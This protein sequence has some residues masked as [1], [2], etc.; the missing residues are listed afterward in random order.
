MIESKVNK[1]LEKKIDL[2]V[3]GILTTEEIDELWIELIQDGYYLD[4][5]KSV[6][7]LKAVIDQKEESQEKS[8][9]FTFQKVARY[10]AAAAVFVIVSIAGIL[11]YSSS[12]NEMVSP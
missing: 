3:N 2:Y 4:Y 11:N 9:I 1:E 5:M 10:A 7:N 8:K 6:V 12:G